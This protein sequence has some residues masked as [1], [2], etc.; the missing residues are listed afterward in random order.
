M[1]LGN[2][3]MGQVQKMSQHVHLV[4]WENG[5]HG[6]RGSII[7]VAPNRHSNALLSVAGEKK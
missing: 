1:S 3:N 4:C 7:P 6:S 5:S 2:E